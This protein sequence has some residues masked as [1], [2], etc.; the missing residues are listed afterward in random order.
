MWTYS[1]VEKYEACGKIGGWEIINWTDQET[2]LTLDN[3]INIVI[4]H[5]KLEAREWDAII[6]RMMEERE[7]VYGAFSELVFGL[8]ALVTNVWD[9]K[10][11]NHDF[12][13]LYVIAH[14]VCRSFEAQLSIGNMS[15]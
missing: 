2:E 7:R 10:Q 9:M 5:S 8:S 4:D 6:V 12:E 11:V 14:S 15:S 3:D 13:C 1:L